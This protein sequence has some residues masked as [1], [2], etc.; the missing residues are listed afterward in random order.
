MSTVTTGSGATLPEFGTVTEA[1]VAAL[2][3]IVGAEAVLTEARQLQSGSKDSYHFSP[4]LIPQLDGRMADVIVRPQTQEQL[5][6]IIQLAVRERI[7][8]TP[9]GAGTGNYGQGVPLFGGILVNTQNLNRLVHISAEEA[10]V[11]AGYILYDIEKAAEGV[12]AELRCF[13]STVPTSHTGGFITGGSGGVGS[14]TWGMLR[15]A[16]NVRAIRILTI[17]EEPQDLLLTGDDLRGVMH[18]CGLTAFVTEVTL[19]LA[20]KVAWQQY[21]LAFDTLRAALGAAETLGRDEGLRKRLLTAFEWPVPSY[22]RPLVKRGGCPEGK[23]LVFLYTDEG[24]EAVASRAQALGGAVTYHDGPRSAETRGFQIYDYTWNHTTQWAMKTDPQLTYLQDG[25]VIER[26]VEQ[27]EARKEKFPEVQE[28]VEFTR[29]DGQLRAGGLS[30]VRF[31]TKERLWDLIEY[32]EANDIQV[33]NPHTY[34]LDDD[35]RWYGEAFLQAKLR[36]DP[37]GLLNPGHLHALENP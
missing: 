32:C 8:L 17:E 34:Y 2:K 24:P 29:G 15:E 25:F 22:F 27:I 36:W 35:T 21:V 10:C 37:H 3:D 9:R 26:L 33:S 23:H 18:N 30:I 28:H 6:Q 20:P 12:G 19:G 1:L 16:D 13:P 5:R 14:I 4:V 11:G 31:S 7:P